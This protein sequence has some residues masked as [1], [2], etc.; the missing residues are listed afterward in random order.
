MNGQAFRLLLPACAD[1]RIR[2]KTVECF[3]SLRDSIGHQERLQRLIQV[4]IGLGVLRFHGGI[5]ERPV[6]PFRLA[7]GPG[8]VELG[9]P[10]VNP[11]LMTVAIQALV[12]GVYC[13]LPMGTREAVI[14]AHRV[15]PRGSGS[16]QVPE[17]RRGDHVVGFCLPFGIGTL[18]GA[19]NRDMQ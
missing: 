11:M 16:H 15:D 18:P 4:V 6:H 10:L 14:G 9:Q 13:V 3:E 8:P 5:F 19:A 17:E 7:M 1:G 2:C 12:N